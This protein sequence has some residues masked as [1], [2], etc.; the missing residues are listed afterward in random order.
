[1]KFSEINRPDLPAFGGPQE[2]VDSEDLDFKEERRKFREETRHFLGIPLSGPNCKDYAYGITETPDGEHL[3]AFS[4]PGDLAGVNAHEELDRVMAGRDIPLI[5][6]TFEKYIR[7]DLDRLGKELVPVSSNEYI[8][9]DGERMI[10]LATAPRS[11]HDMEPDFHFWVRGWDLFWSHKPGNM[12]VTDRVGFQKI[13][14]PAKCDYGLYADF[15]GYYVIRDKKEASMPMKN[16]D[17]RNSGMDIQN[18]ERTPEVFQEI[19]SM[20]QGTE[21]EQMEYSTNLLEK[22]LNQEVSKTEAEAPAVREAA[23]QE[24]GLM[25][26]LERVMEILKPDLSDDVA[27]FTDESLYTH[28]PGLLKTE[29]TR[30][31]GPG[32]MAFAYGAPT[33][34]NGE[35][36]DK[37]LHLGEFDPDHN[38]PEWNLLELAMASGDRGWI[39][40]AFEPHMRADLA[41]LNKELFLA[42]SADYVPQEGERMITL[43]VSPST[44][45]PLLTKSPN[46][47]FFVHGTDGTFSYKDGLDD[48]V[49]KHHMDLY[50]DYLDYEVIEH[51]LIRDRHNDAE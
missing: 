6:S 39:K 12:P 13:E 28:K 16:G 33:L 34:A 14:D 46:Y 50:A 32:K 15:I 9:K 35:K 11:L 5:R 20:F 37:Y 1:M 24:S 44:Y 38:A 42:P 10:A 8:P 17:I 27:R 41:V 40:N 2:I 22:F 51:Y 43:A 36:Y 7:M 31:A 25:S 30:N 49:T 29:R 26:K 47:R 3:G 18:P 19:R 45:R 21:A 48:P 23:Q 4:W